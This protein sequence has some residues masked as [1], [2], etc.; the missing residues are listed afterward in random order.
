[1][2]DYPELRLPFENQSTERTAFAPASVSWTI[3]RTLIPQFETTVRSCNTT[4]AV[5]LLACWQVLLWRLTGQAKV[6]VGMAFPGR[7]VEGLE[8]LPGLFE[9]YLPFAG[10]LEGQLKFSELLKQ[11]DESGIRLAEWQ[12]Y[13]QWDSSSEPRNYTDDAQ[14]FPICFEFDDRPGSFSAGITGSL[15][16]QYSCT[17]P[18]KIKLSCRLEKESLTTELHYDPQLFGA[19]DVRTVAEQFRTLLIDA[20]NHLESPI[21]RLELLSDSVRQQLLFDF[22]HTRV[23]Q[24]HFKLVHQEI[25]A[26][27]ARTPE[28]TAVVFGQ[29]QL[30]YAELN[31]RANKLARH[32]RRLGVGPDVP[33]VLCL[34]R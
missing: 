7:G 25:E 4:P 18:F 28:R 8:S 15:L 2:S 20:L 10:Q 1:M 33:V 21:D 30:S 32:L 23:D 12:D 13:F 6:L 3:N 26:Q 27:A 5:F 11:L 24:S 9:R 14:F 19:E 34:E 29:Q 31:G 22:N 17:E 16:K